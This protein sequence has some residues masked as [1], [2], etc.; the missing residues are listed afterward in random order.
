MA[1]ALVDYDTLDNT[2]D[3]ARR[4]VSLGRRPSFIVST[5]QQL[6]GRGRHKREWFSPRGNIAITIVAA[7]ESSRAEIQT[8]S[9]VTGL[10]VY[11]AVAPLLPQEVHLKIKWPN[12][13]L[14]DDAKLSG[15]LLLMEDE[16]LYVGIGLNLVEAPQLEYPTAALKRYGQFD[17]IDLV[18]AIGTAW[19]ARFKNWLEA[20]FGP[21]LAQFNDRLWGLGCK[22]VVTDIE[23]S[24]LQNTGT[25][26]GVTE[27]GFLKLEMGDGTT[28]E[29]STGDVRSVRRQG[30]TSIE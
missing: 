24:G 5:A 10:A 1:Y 2:I 19:E 14:V 13:L 21:S 29:F 22:L 15:T 25:C 16:L 18:K 7:L 6:D 27:R 20:G 8:L 11:D 4:L 23:T 9:L 3:E 30:I 12:D 28:R 26:K 17:R